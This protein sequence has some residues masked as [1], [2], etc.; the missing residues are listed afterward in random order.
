[1]KLA[2]RSGGKIKCILIL[3]CLYNISE[4]MFA[5][6]FAKINLK[7]L[8]PDIPMFKEFKGKCQ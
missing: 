3:G 6:T 7:C 5:E 4:I 2:H 1:M 8:G